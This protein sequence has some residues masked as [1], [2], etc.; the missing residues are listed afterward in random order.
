MGIIGTSFLTDKRPQ[1]F[2]KDFRPLW[3][4]AL[5]PSG[6]TIIELPSLSFFEPC[7][8]TFFKLANFL[9]L[10]K[11][12][13]LR[14]ANAHPKKGMN[15]NSLFIILDDGMHRVCKNRDSQVPWW[16]DTRMHGLLGR[17]SI[18]SI[19]Q[20]TPHNTFNDFKIKPIH[21]EATL[22]NLVVFIKGKRRMSNTETGR[23]VTYNIKLNKKLLIVCNIKILF[24]L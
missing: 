18:P 6:K 10:L 20:V 3:G 17:F 14:H 16:F 19:V 5:V 24:Y 15:N 22:C 4:L 1:L 11:W 7:F 8:K 23:I 21:T 12:I 9:D 13:G 2:E